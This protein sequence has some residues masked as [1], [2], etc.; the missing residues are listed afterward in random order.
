MIYLCPKNYKNGKYIL[1]K[2]RKI[3][4]LI[5]ILSCVVAIIFFIAITQIGLATQN[6]KIIIFGLILA[7]FIALSGTLLIL[8]VPNYHNVLEFLIIYFSYLSK[9]KKYKYK[10]INY[11]GEDKL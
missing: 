1:S 3:D 2:F 6:I 4:L 5:L 10:G 8:K 11:K 9:N 7:V